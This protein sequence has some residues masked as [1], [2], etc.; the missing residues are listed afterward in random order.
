MNTRRLLNVAGIG[1]L[2]GR[3]R[4]DLVS[5][6]L[7]RNKAETFLNDNTF[8]NKP[9]SGV[10]V[11]IYYAETTEISPP[12]FRKMKDGYLQVEI[13]LEMKKLQAFAKD[14]RLTDVFVWALL[15]ALKSTR[16]KY[17][18]TI[19][20]LESELSKYEDIKSDFCNP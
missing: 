11:I 8:S 17:E 1:L 9:F 13:G 2:K 5:L 4:N 10:I 12:S 16:D 6:N 20:G 14:S 15:E 3:I 19:V 18:L 7:A